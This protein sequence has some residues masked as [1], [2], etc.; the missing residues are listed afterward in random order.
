MG[1]I[2][3]GIV[4]G[5]VILIILFLLMLPVNLC[6]KNGKDGQPDLYFRIL[7]F[8]FSGKSKENNKQKRIKNFLGLSKGKEKKTDKKEET[9]PNKIKNILETLWSF[10]SQADSL[11]KNCR[12]TRLKLKIVCAG[13]DAAE[14]A[15]NY[16]IV[17]ATVYNLTGYLSTALKVKNNAIKVDI[18][19]DYVANNGS[20]EYDVILYL[21]VW[22]LLSSL[23]RISIEK[24][25]EQRV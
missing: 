21:R 10:L 4:F 19:C 22:V 3:T 6:V 15:V 24:N 14:T 18:S 11:F 7:W 1:W 20:I 9:F 5:V 12:V 13:E 23:L 16:G 25:K 2:I 17:C 8:K